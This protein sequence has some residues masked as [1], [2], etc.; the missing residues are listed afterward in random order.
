MIGAVPGT[1][2]GGPPLVAVGLYRAKVVPR[3][4]AVLLG[5]SVVP[6]YVAPSAGVLGAVLHLP[7]C[8][9]IA[10]LGVEV[11]RANDLRDRG[12]LLPDRQANLAQA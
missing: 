6:V 9:A 3:W 4:P 8:V 5:G 11:W 2:A 10:G 7:L 12:S 1:S